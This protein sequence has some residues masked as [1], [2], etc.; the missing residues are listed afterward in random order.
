MTRSQVEF[1]VGELVMEYL[2]KERFPI[3]TYNKLKLKNIGPCNFLRKFSSNAYEI[4]LPRDIGISTI[5]NV[6]DLYPFKGIEDVS[7]DEPVSDEDQTIG[8]KEQL[9]RTIQKDIEIVLDQKVTKK[10]RGKEYF[11]YLVKWKNQPVEDATWMTPIE[12]YKYDTSV[13]D[14]KNSYFL[15]CESDA[16]ASSSKFRD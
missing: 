15:P 5:F 12:I 2:R 14:L 13:E 11:Q 6:V 10:T 7:T 8:W 1:K 3:E 4:E 16:G 9:P